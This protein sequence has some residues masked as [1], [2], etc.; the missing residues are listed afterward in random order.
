MMIHAKLEAELL[1]EARWLR[2]GRG[3][4]QE[5]EA[6]VKSFSPRPRPNFVLEASL[7]S[8]F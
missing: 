5:L 7:A 1:N 4:G 8:R 2:S 3:R 6:E